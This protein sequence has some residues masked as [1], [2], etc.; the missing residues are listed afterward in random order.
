MS[1]HDA[2]L[3]ERLKTGISDPDS[4]EDVAALVEEALGSGISALVIVEALTGGIK[5]LGDKFDSMEI[6]LPELIMGANT[7][8]EAM[9]ILTPEI[10]KQGAKGTTVPARF[11]IANLQGDIHD[12]GREIVVTMCRVAGFT[13]HN[14]GH[15]V[16]AD[17][18]IDAAV[19]N[20][21][22]FIGLS[23]LLTTSLPFAKDLLSLLDARGL[24]DRFKVLMGGGAVTP[25]YSD[26]IGADGYSMT[27]TDAVNVITRMYSEKGA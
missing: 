14:L 16:K 10:E 1:Q 7:M 12:I 18:I 17:A 21:S 26:K 5:I 24:R 6:F 4:D 27:A 22:D 19:D 20:N 8:E 13:V 11:I 25:E 23:S 9:R 3:M 2:D 15:D